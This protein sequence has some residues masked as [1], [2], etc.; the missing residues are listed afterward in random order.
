MVDTIF[1]C[2]NEHKFINKMVAINNIIKQKFN[3]EEDLSKAISLTAIGIIDIKKK[4]ILYPE[5]DK[6]NESNV[7]KLTKL[8]EKKIGQAKSF[9]IE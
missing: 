3:L 1:D 8:I 7:T 9:M 2:I 5:Q 4:D 6:N